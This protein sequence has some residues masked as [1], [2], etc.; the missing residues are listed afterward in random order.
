MFL[1]ISRG[2]AWHRSCR[3]ETAG[4]KRSAAWPLDRK[5]LGMASSACLWT[6]RAASPTEFDF[7]AFSL[8]R[9]GGAPGVPV[10]ETTQAGV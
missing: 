2:D 3:Y 7:N 9:S 1:W 4:F 10:M 8:R 6:D 5:K